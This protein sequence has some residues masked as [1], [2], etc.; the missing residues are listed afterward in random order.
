MYDIIRKLLIRLLISS[1]K[2]NRFSFLADDITYD[3]NLFNTIIIHKLFF[4]SYSRLQN[5]TKFLGEVNT[6]INVLRFVDREL[7]RVWLK[8]KRI[9]GRWVDAHIR[10]FSEVIKQGNIALTIIHSDLFLTD[11]AVDKSNNNNKKSQ[12]TT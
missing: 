11:F 7:T 4:I 9:S 6:N 5:N 2:T 1:V 12:L 8:K 3:A 10:F